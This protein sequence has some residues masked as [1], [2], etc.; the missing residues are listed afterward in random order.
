MSLSSN[1]KPFVSVLVPV[2]GVER[3]IADCARSLLAQCETD[4]EFLFI[5]DASPDNSIARLQE[6][7]AACPERAA[8][9]RI[10]HHDRNR[11][12]AAARRTAIEAAQGEYILHVDSDD[13][14]NDD[15]AL[16]RLSAEARRTDADLVFGGYCEHSSAGERRHAAPQPDRRWILR[17]LLRQDF[18]VGNRIWGILIRRSLHTGYGLC[19][20]EGL[21]FAE[22]YALLPRLVYHAAGIAAVDRPLYAYRT[23]NAASYMNTLSERS[24]EAYIEANRLITE[25]IRRQPDSLRWQRELTLGK[26]NVAKWILKRGYSPARYRDRLFGPDDL[27]RGPLQR[28]YAAALRTERLPLVRA[29]AALVNAL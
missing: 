5:D 21:N 18:R 4:A 8:R 6:V 25:F 22:D 11:G 20:V 16:A 27:P 14:L 7:L 10:L 26:L 3:Y 2:Y 23:A 17:H 9:A 29:V 13:F 28:L 12:L 1:H 24:V 15:L 19:P